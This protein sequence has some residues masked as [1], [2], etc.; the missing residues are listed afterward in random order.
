[1]PEKRIKQAFQAM[2]SIS[3]S[4]LTKKGKSDIFVNRRNNFV[5]NHVDAYR[6]KGDDNEI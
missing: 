6:Y 4:M 1:M 5:T 2:K 3:W